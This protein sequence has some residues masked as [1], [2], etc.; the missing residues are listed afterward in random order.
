VEAI[1]IATT[2]G[3]K[4]ITASDGA[5]AMQISRR[6]FLQRAALGAVGVPTALTAAWA[7]TYPSRP[8]RIVVNLAAGG[9]T[10]FLARLIGA[11]VS[12]ETSQQFIIENRVG[13]GGLVGAEMV[14]KSTPDGYTLLASHD[15]VASAPPIV[16][17]STDYL[18]KLVP[19]IQLS[20][21]PLVLVVHPSLGVS[22]VAELINLTK[23]SPGMAYATSGAGTQQHYIGEWFA[24]TAGIRLEHVPYRGAGQAV[25][26]LL[27]GHV[28][29][30]SLGPTPIVP[31]HRAG[32]LR[33][34]AQSAKHVHPPCPMSRRFTRRASAAS[35]SKRGMPC[36]PHQEPRRRS[37]RA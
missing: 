18:K 3:A 19:I 13:A 11:Y 10:D 16:S 21:A 24:Q 36:S 14:A 32:T 4:E 22:T 1:G 35:Y 17:A 28:R 37:S 6:Q 31:Q 5:F 34:L 29:I 2:P 30:G 8:V 15:V 12:Q 20:R 25:N 33:I 7:E 26:D 27:A 9:G 23:Q